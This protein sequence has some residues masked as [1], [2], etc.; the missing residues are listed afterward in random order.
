[1]RVCIH[2]YM[3]CLFLCIYTFMFMYIY[4]YIHIYSYV[5]VYIYIN[6]NLY[7][8]IY[9]HIYIYVYIYIIYVYITCE[10]RSIW[11]PQ[12]SERMTGAPSYIMKSNHPKDP[13]HSSI[14]V[15]CKQIH[16]D[17]YKILMS[18]HAHTNICTQIRIYKLTRL[19]KRVHSMGIPSTLKVYE[20]SQQPL[21]SGTLHLHMHT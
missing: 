21:L 20:N 10:G 17:Q 15:P 1:V 6:S 11:I 19:W 18:T 9:I 4:I 16:A 7:I 12:V 14:P 5:Y 8:C 2:T 3:I 13:C